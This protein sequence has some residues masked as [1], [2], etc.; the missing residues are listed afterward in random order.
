MLH[1]RHKR[2][3]QV[4]GILETASLLTLKLLWKR[5]NRLRLFPGMVF[6]D[7]VSL[8]GHDRWRS[9]DIF[10]LLPELR[11]NPGKIVLQPM[12]GEGVQTPI[13]EL[14]YLAL[15]TVSLQPKVIFEFGTFRGRTAL[16]FALNSPATCRIFTIDL[17]PDA[18]KEGLA[19]VNSADA[20]LIHASETG[21][22]FRESE[23][24]RKI[25][26]LHGDSTRFDFQ[27]FFG[28]VDLVFVDGGH[29]YEVARSD[30]RNALEMVRSGGVVV[31]HDFANYGDYHDV[32]RA[33][34]DEV[35][36]DQVVQI[37]NT[38]LAIYRKP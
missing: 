26:Q 24:S 23:E 1:T 35:G 20:F 19:H 17:E 34:L 28:Q 31:W 16:N 10:D 3:R 37:A 9:A 22:D 15:L 27:P 36:R 30:T 6:R 25:E 29:D 21:A 32:V 11:R 12:P 2:L 13:D 5:P 38:Q 33:V 4:A 18:R 8:V 14:A 7:Y